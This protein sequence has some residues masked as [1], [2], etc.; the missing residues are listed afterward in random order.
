MMNEGQQLSTI[1]IQG[2]EVTLSQNQTGD[3]SEVIDVEIPEGYRYEFPSTRPMELFMFTHESKTTNG[4]A[5][6]TETFA[7]ANDLINS[8]AMSDAPVSAGQADLVLFEDGT[9]VAP[10]SVNYS[11]DEFTFTNN[12]GGSTLDVYY[13]WGDPSKIE[14]RAYDT[15]LESY[16]VVVGETANALHSAKTFS[17]LEQIT[18]NNNFVLRESE[19]LQFHINTSVDLSNWEV[20]DGSGPNG[21]DSPSNMRLPVYKRRT[22]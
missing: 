21:T 6:T 3:F 17:E 7:L 13:L 1:G 9:Q 5:G 18:Y 8:P 11:A 15:T 10:D 14:A 2:S 16:D 20:V 4:T 22:E 19:H 12:T